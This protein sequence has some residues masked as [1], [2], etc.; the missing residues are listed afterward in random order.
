MSFIARTGVVSRTACD[1]AI[2]SKQIDQTLGGLAHRG[3]A[4]RKDIALSRSLPAEVAL[5][6]AARKIGRLAGKHD[7]LL[8]HRGPHE[9]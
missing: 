6:V 5:E 4:V 1:Q 2:V 9:S 8:G 3:I 7:S